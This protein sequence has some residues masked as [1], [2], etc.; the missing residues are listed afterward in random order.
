MG[1]ILIAWA[2]LVVVIIS[3]PADDKKPEVKSSVSGSVTLNGKPLNECMISFHPTD[4][5]KVPF[6]T[7]T[8]KDGK[9]KVE[10]PDGEYT[11]TCLKIVVDEATKKTITV[12]PD[13][14]ANPRTSGL[15][16]AVKDGKQTFDIALMSK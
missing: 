16:V 5:T 6:P 9:F 12:T 14:Y 3:A 13:K 11:V 1:R 15:K 10:L 8:D 7:K 2:A 4:N